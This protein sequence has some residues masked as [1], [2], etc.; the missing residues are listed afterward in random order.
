M[1]LEQNE[2]CIQQLA[3]ELHTTHKTFSSHLIV[4]H[5]AGIVSRRRQGSRAYY[6]LTDYTSYMPEI[7]GKPYMARGNSMG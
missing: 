6:A 3:D 2:A 7:R 4:L 5:P 1:L